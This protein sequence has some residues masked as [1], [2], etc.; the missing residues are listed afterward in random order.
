MIK[1]ELDDF[2]RCVRNQGDCSNGCLAN[3]LKVE[4][5]CDEFPCCEDCDEYLI[6]KA[7]ELNLE[8]E[9]KNKK[10]FL[11]KQIKEKLEEDVK[12]IAK[13]IAM[14]KEKMKESMEMLREAI[15]NKTDKEID[16]VNNPPH[17]KVHK[18]ECIDEMVAVFGAGA[19]KKF[20]M[21]NAWKYRYRAGAKNGEEKEKDLA[22]ADWYISKVIELN[23][24]YDDEGR[25]RWF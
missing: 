16:D 18:H 24:E 11:E 5:D 15:K 20:C 3:L 10:E 25:E 21:C 2:I 4:M 23:E 6:K 7:K 22:K 19:V 13:T 12:D 14:R 17:Y 9:M 8:D 1:I